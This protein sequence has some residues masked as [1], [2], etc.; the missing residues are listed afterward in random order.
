MPMNKVAVTK[1]SA[2]LPAVDDLFTSE[3]ILFDLLF[4]SFHAFNYGGLLLGRKRF[5]VENLSRSYAEA[6]QL[7]PD[8]LFF[9]PRR[10]ELQR[11]VEIFEEV[12]LDQLFVD[13]GEIDGRCCGRSGLL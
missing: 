13:L 4:T 1:V 2:D 12:R 6:S 8:L 3:E 10:C 7:R 5:E 9:R 11:E